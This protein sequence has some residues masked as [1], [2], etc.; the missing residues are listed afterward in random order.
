MNKTAFDLHSNNHLSWMCDTNLRNYI[1][2]SLDALKWP[3]I[4]I[5]KI[6]ASYTVSRSNHWSYYLTSLFCAIWKEM[7][8][9][10]TL[11]EWNISNIY[12]TFNKMLSDS[13]INSTV[14]RRS[15]QNRQRNST[16][17]PK[18][19]TESTGIPYS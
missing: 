18:S 2:I 13:P 5:S 19:L 14:D 1:F 6:H 17:W 8:H 16:I 7:K 4:K 15:L 11:F 12:A 9:E 3:S 10:R